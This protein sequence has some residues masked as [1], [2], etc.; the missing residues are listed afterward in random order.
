MRILT[1]QRHA[2]A[3]RTCGNRRLNESI[4]PVD[5]NGLRLL[6]CLFE[7]ITWRH[8]FVDVL[9]FGDDSVHHGRLLQGGEDVVQVSAACDLRVL[10]GLPI[11]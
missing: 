11:G 8:A 3:W 5:R 10:G 4:I 6:S 2:V 1:L 7:W 9:M